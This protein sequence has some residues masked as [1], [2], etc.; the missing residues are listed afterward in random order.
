MFIVLRNVP[1]LLT[2]CV[3]NLY[4]CTW[5]QLVTCNSAQYAGER[6]TDEVQAKFKANIVQFIELIVDL[7]L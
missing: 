1:Q 2:V 4:L 7:E 5:L 3:K 6:K